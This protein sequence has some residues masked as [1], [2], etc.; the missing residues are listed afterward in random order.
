MISLGGVRDSQTI[1]AVSTPSGYGGIS[2]IRL[3]GDSAALVAHKCISKFPTKP[4][5]HRAYFGR[6]FDPHSKQEI[7]QIVAVYFEKDHSYTGEFTIEIS[8]H[9]NPVIC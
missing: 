7:D 4:E 3:S 8:C 9:G 6:F 2:V 5:S 1:C